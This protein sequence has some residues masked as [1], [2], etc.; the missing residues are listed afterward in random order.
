[1]SSHAWVPLLSELSKGRPKTH[2]RSGDLFPHFNGCHRHGIAFQPNQNE[3][4]LRLCVC[5][6][7]NNRR[8]VQLMDKNLKPEG[9][10]IYQDLKLKSLLAD[11]FGFTSQ[12]WRHSGYESRLIPGTTSYDATKNIISAKWN[13]FSDELTCFSSESNMTFKDEWVFMGGKG[14]TW[15]LNWFYRHAAANSVSCTSVVHEKWEQ[16]VC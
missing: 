8:N 2:S 10:V 5:V 12:R 4:V 7:C 3:A 9:S 16:M 14:F 13:V 1:M 6:V 15:F 11:M